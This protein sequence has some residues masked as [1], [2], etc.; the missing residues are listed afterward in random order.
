MPDTLC[1]ADLADGRRAL[2][3]LNQEA[4]AAQLVLILRPEDMKPRRIQPRPP[5]Q[6]VLVYRV[7]GEGGELLGECT[8]PVVLQIP[9]PP[10]KPRITPEDLFRMAKEPI[11][12]KLETRQEKLLRDIENL[13]RGNDPEAPATT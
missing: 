5:G 10:P 4:G 3:Y 9:P 1:I 6:P 13:Q 2:C 8:A 12:P 11:A 7:Y